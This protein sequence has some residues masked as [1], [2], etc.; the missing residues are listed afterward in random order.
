MKVLVTGA[1][2]YIGTVLV[3]L[4]LEKGYDVIA[5]DRFFFGRTL[6]DKGIKV[7]EDDVR[8]VEPDILRGVDGVIDLAALSNDPSGELDPIKTWS[9]NYLGRF[10]IANLSKRMGVRKYVFSSSCSV[11]GFRED[12]ADESSSTN[13]L[14]TYAKANLKGERDILPLTDKNFSVTVFRIATVYGYARTKRMR[15]DL[16]INA[17][18]RD[19]ITKNK[20]S[21]MKDGTQWRPFVHVWDVA[22]A[23]SLALEKDENGEIFNLGSDDQNYQIFD[24]AVRIT[25]ALGKELNYE[26]Y[27][28]PDKRS[29]RVSFKKIREKFGFVP[30]YRAEDAAREIADAIVSGELDPNDPRYITVNWY[31]TL[32]AKGELI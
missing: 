12:V 32:L 25:K 20:I 5:L 22:N 11:Y 17:F 15:F 29:Y 7:V 23:L 8:F 14:T 16:V 3:P 9:I 21:I 18:V 4:L 24:L 13:P 2:G 28:S 27:G 19:F 10:R 6:E 26:W 31:K 1:G 30:K